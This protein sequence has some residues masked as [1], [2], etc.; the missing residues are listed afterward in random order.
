MKQEHLYLLAVLLILMVF[1]TL[2]IW[3]KEANLEVA[4]Y[5]VW[6]G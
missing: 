6:S 2:T 4:S 1:I 3:I 5:M